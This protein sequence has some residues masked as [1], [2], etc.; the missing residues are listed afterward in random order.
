M[1]VMCERTLIYIEPDT[2]ITKHLMASSYC[3]MH[4]HRSKL[5]TLDCG[6]IRRTMLIVNLRNIL[7][8]HYYILARKGS[9]QAVKPWGA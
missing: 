4:G 2:I 6:E 7:K 1:Q 5:A 8:F 9:A 3:T